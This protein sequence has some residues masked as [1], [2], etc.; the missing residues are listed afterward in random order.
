MPWITTPIVLALSLALAQGLESRITYVEGSVALSADSV[1][2]DGGRAEL[3]LAS[4]TLVHV[5]GFSTVQFDRLGTLT[6][7]SGRLLVRTGNRG[8]SDVEVPYARLRLAPSGVYNILAD[9]AH[10]RLLVS[11]IAGRVQLQGRYGQGTSIDPTQMV[12]MTS[13][14]S[15]PWAA[16][17]QPAGW[18]RFELWSD[19]RLAQV[20]WQSGS[21]SYEALADSGVV[22]NTYPASP[23]CSS[24]MS[25]DNPCWIVPPQTWPGRP[26]YRPS[27][28]NYAPNYRPNYTPHYNVPPPG[29]PSP[30][31]HGPSTGRP[32]RHGPGGS[33]PETLPSARPGRPEAPPRATPP[34]SSPPPAAGSNP[35]PAPRGTGGGIRVPER[36][37]PR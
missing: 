31:P 5:D 15:T 6:L 16:P 36:P 22:I 10:G 7:T 9:A 1:S 32:E 34:P 27:P 20:A 3:V 19:S 28:P 4:G 18:D 26:P 33:N 8:P 11:V 25:V 30:T 12:I 21:A 13:P 17:F 35:K 2:T 24:W 37:A 29:V 23:T 14:T